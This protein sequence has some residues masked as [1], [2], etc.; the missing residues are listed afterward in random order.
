MGCHLCRAPTHTRKEGGAP[1]GHRAG[2]EMVE[3]TATC[4]CPRPGPEQKDAPSPLPTAP[5]PTAMPSHPKYPPKCLP[6]SLWAQHGK[7][8]HPLWP[9]RA[10]GCPEPPSSGGP[11]VQ[12]PGAEVERHI[13]DCCPGQTGQS[14]RSS[15]GRGRSEQPPGRPA[16]LGC[17]WASAVGG[18]IP[19]ATD[20]AHLAPVPGA[21]GG[22]PASAARAHHQAL[23]SASSQPILHQQH[24]LGWAGGGIGSSG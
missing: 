17:S 20:R 11:G 16:G 8:H 4:S 22:G 9:W 1:V 12:G 24:A 2:A 15:K 19:G 21:C 13:E 23:P 5:L 10:P 14:P 7:A 6:H 3:V 18:G